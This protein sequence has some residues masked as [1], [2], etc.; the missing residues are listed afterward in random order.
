MNYCIVIPMYKEKLDCTEILS[1]KRLHKIIY[2]DECPTGGEDYRY[3]EETPVFLVIPKG[4]NIDEYK[5]IYPTIKVKEFDKK[6]FESINNLSRLMFEYDFYKQFS[7]Y[8]YMLIYQLDGY[9]FKNDIQSWCDKGYDYIGGPIFSENSGWKDN[10]DTV[11][12]PKV[13]NGGISLRKIKFFMDLNNP[14]GE[15]RT[16]YKDKYNDKFFESIKFEDLEYYKIFRYYYDANI[17]TWF[18]AGLFS[19][20]MNPEVF[21]SI[22]SD[23][24]DHISLCHAWPKN[25]R[26]WKDKIPE[27]NQDIIDF[28]EDKYKDFFKLY[29]GEKK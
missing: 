11:W 6:C 26:Y 7:R 22:I 3:W 13:G 25:I 23:P 9:I 8:D 21:E 10:N 28:C 20:D 14:N 12:S 29:Y 19:L 18:E 5:K 2:E 16:Y 17:P 1:L 4:L 24:K 15:F 27:I